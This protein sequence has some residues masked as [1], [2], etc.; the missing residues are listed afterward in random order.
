MFGMLYYTTLKNIHN[1]LLETKF[2]ILYDDIS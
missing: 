2:K 1:L